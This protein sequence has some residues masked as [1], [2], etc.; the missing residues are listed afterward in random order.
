[1]QSPANIQVVQ[2][3]RKWKPLALNMYLGF[4]GEEKQICS[5]VL[6]VKVSNK[7]LLQ[8]PGCAETH[9]LESR[10]DC[11]CHHHHA[12]NSSEAFKKINV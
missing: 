6:I 4:K 9:Q 3:I 1:M 8:Q 11:A 12:Q 5:Y 2:L 7:Q 10:E